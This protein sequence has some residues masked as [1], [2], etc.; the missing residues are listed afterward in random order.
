MSKWIKRIIFLL[1]LG[2]IGFGI[3]WY[4]G[5]SDSAIVTF[6]TTPIQTL[7]ITSTIGSTGTLQAED[8]VDIGAQVQGQILSF[9][10]DKAGNTVNYNSRVAEGK[11]L[12]TIDDSVYAQDEAATKAQLA[13]A[14]ASLKRAIADLQQMNAKLFQAERDWERAKNLGTGDALSRTE[15]DQFDAAYRIAKANIGIG[16][17]AIAQAEAGVKAADSQHKKAERNLK[18]C[19]ILSPVDGV[20]IARRVN[21]GQ[22]VVS[23]LNAPS[24]FLLA[25]D[26]TKLL[27]IASVNEADIGNITEKQK[28]DFTVDAYP[29]RIFKGEV[30]RVRLMAQM[31]Q[32]V[33]TYPVEIVVDNAD[34]KLLPYETTNVTFKVATRESTLAVPNAALR[35]MPTSMEQIV[36][37]ARE[38][39][40]K[41]EGGNGGGGGG[42]GGERGQGGG[43]RQKGGGDASATAP[44]GDASST[45]PTSRPSG[46]GEG[47][48][49]GMPEHKWGTIWLQEGAFVKPQRVK[50]GL[51]DGINTE[52][53]A[54]GLK[55]NLQVVIGEIRQGQGGNEEA[56]NPFLPQF[57]NRRSGGGGSGGGPRGGR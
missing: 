46:R 20:V 31:T 54:E 32:N 50:L 13:Q 36:P 33:V 28:V 39:L 26:L 4:F 37:E 25:K 18:F 30:R 57:G 23:S 12:A 53:I 11:M 45:Q 47:M 1:I 55:P 38:A 8:T 51:T 49:A 15:Y 6:R 43:R 35:W 16:E 17:A 2:G 19:T 21:I 5:R 10:V 7:T 52:V 24:L 29:G 42:G 3:W 44:S 40:A 27:I 22:T 9:G 14:D 56:N 48:T 34:G 41:G